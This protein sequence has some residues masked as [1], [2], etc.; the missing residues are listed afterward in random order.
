MMP[1]P[2]PA[3]VSINMSRPGRREPARE[4]IGLPGTSLDDRPPPHQYPVKYR[5]MLAHWGRWSAEMKRDAERRRGKPPPLRFPPQR[6]S[7]DEY[8][9]EVMT[10]YWGRRYTEYRRIFERARRGGMIPDSP[11]YVDFDLMDSCNLAC[12]ACT[13]NFR[14]WTRKTLDLDAVRN[15]PF[16]A[17]ENLPSAN[18]G[19][20]NEPFL[21]PGPTLDLLRF[22][23]ERK[24]MDIFL[25]TNGNLLTAEIIDELIRSGLT[26]LSLSIDAATEETYRVVR[27]RGFDNV[28]A[29]AHKVLE[30][31]RRAGLQLGGFPAG[32]HV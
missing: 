1:L 6:W 24:V 3:S 32:L 22:L 20:A 18:I 30:A 2:Y 16:F 23:R 14:P 25:H 13:E 15:D 8:V 28:L 31:R 7:R 26:W 9:R 11:I 27:G 19:R 29:N 10:R 17:A 5:R 4:V 21:T 12:P